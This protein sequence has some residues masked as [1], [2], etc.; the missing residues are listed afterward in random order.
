V[1]CAIEARRSTCVTFVSHLPF[2]SVG[3]VRGAS[4]S[5]P[6]PPLKS[7]SGGR[8]AAAK[9]AAGA[10]TRGPSAGSSSADPSLSSAPA[11]VGVGVSLLKPLGLE[12]SPDDLTVLA[13]SDKRQIARER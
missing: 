2:L 12:L 3:S 13:V 11:V 4:F 8:A 5:R 1:Q 7:G 6:A 9:A 10:A